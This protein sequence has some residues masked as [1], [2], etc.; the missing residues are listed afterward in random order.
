LIGVKISAAKN[1]YR[2]IDSAMPLFVFPSV[3]LLGSANRFKTTNRRGLPT[4]LVCA[5]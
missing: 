4:G 3:I 5:A 2:F 1:V